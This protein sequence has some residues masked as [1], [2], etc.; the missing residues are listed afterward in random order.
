LNTYNKA[1]FYFSLGDS[2]LE[3]LAFGRKNTRKNPDDQQTTPVSDP[4]KLLKPRGYLKQTVASTSKVYQ[5]KTTQSNAKGPLEQLTPQEDS[6]QI[7][8]GETSTDKLETEIINP[9]LVLPEIKAETDSTDPFT[10][11]GKRPISIPCSY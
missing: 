6:T 3:K 8:F 10:S 7:H 1:N 11:K 5:P 4:E 9:E 2:T